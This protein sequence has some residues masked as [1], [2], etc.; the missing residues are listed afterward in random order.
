MVPEDEY[1]CT[2]HRLLA[3]N[4]WVYRTIFTCFD[5]RMYHAAQARSKQMSSCHCYVHKCV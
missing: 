3:K 1:K 2:I 4:D 5:A